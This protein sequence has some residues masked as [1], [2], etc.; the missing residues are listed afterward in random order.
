MMETISVDS[1]EDL[2]STLNRLPN[3]Y[4]YRGQ[5]NATWSLQSSLERIVGTKWSAEEAKRFEEFSVGQFRSKFHLYD[6]EN[7]KP[8]SK[9]AWLSLMQHY[10]V[11][12]RLL[13]FTES[14]YIA[15][16]FALETYSP[17]T[18]NDLALYAL[19]YSAILEKSI[20]YIRTRDVE[21]RETRATV[22]HRQDEI[23]ERIVDRFSYDIAWIAE[24]QVLNTRL[25]K[26]AGSFLLSGNRG[27]RIQEVLSSPLYQEVNNYKFL[28]PAELYTGLFA[29]L[30]KM[31]ITSKSLYGDLDGL[32]R[33]IRMQMQVYSV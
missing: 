28:L 15:L 9:L 25:D 32:A 26:Q 4:L 27:M 12:T 11:P 5:A 23:F 7:I 17:Q 6:R 31:N 30:R 16:Y 8:E 19:D 33:S 20:G 10:G 21:F 24:P 2:I 14:P 3:N 22:Y 29:L 18:G 13:D 1:V